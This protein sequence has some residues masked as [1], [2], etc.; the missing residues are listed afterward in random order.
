M[1][2]LIYKNKRITHYMVSLKCIRWSTS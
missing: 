2:L 1:I